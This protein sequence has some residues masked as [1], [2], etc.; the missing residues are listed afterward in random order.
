[1][2]REKLELVTDLYE[3]TMSNGYFE[4]QRNEIAYFDIFFRNVPDGGGYAIA[5]GLN[6]VIDYI[7]NLRF[8]KED[9]EYLQNINHMKNMEKSKNVFNLRVF[10]KLQIYWRY[11]GNP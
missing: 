9:I 3:F 5:A 2:N 10:I 11:M 1:M 4:K 6:E 7:Q 8:D